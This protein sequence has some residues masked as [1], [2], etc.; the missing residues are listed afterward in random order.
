MASAS[1]CK[2]SIAWVYAVEDKLM[3][4]FDITSYVVLEPNSYSRRIL[5][6]QVRCI[7]C[8]EKLFFVTFIIS[9]Y[10]GVSP[11]QDD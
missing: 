6:D 8:T 2:R 10:E 5:N 4:W 3:R 9:S 11:T 1:N 7:G